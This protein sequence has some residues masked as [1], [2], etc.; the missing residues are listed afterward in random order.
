MKKFWLTLCLLI[1]AGA[2]LW[3]YRERIPY[4]AAMLGTPPATTKSTDTAQN[5]SQKK[6][7]APVVVK[8]VAAVQTTLPMDVTAT[9]WVVPID[10]TT[11]AAQE[12]GIV[13]QIIAED[14]ATVKAGDL[15]AKL[16]PRTAQAAV[17]KDQAMYAK[18]Q[19]TLAEAETALTRAQS[20]L[21]GNA[22]SQA[23]A[24]EARETRDAAVATGNGD[25]AQLAADQVL[26]EHTDV[27]AP[28]DGRLGDVSLSIGA[29]VSP[30]TAIVTIAKYNPAYIKFNMQENNLRQ[31]QEALAA[32]PVPVSTVP[33]SEKGKARQG[34]VSFFDNTVD[35]TSGTII[36]KA[37]FDNGNGA[38][39]PGR[40]ENVVVH[41]ADQEQLVVVPTVA[42]SPGPDGFIS[43]V[44]GKDNK[45]HITPVT[46]AR[47]NGDR[48]AVA[49]GL[50]VGDH[51]VIE[52]QSQITN[53]QTI[54]EEFGDG[55]TQK[56]ASADDAK[57]E[58]IAVG[59]QQ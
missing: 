19:A 1:V 32:G 25:K 28:Y 47:A 35:Q 50:S 9:G 22:G 58:T 39:W 17:D 8:T 30:G 24:D 12:A 33:R 18:D 31:L 11:I 29:Y 36:V 45:V 52:G 55:T 16:D 6:P 3:T 38:L 37:K 20:L 10:Q 34:Q 40:S 42:V 21:S 41:F 51:V 57:T 46:V 44:V 59:A 53:G 7:G 14:G 15:I 56:V 54:K 48:T 26:L 23:T 13:T 27:R 5:G 43:F 49:K 2:A 4:L